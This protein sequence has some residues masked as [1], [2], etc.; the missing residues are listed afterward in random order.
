MLGKY[1]AS[2]DE[3]YQ[4][5]EEKLIA[6]TTE[7]NEEVNSLYLRINTKQDIR[8]A[9]VSL[10]AVI[11]FLGLYLGFVF[12]ISG[13]AILALKA[14]SDSIDSSGRYHMLRQ[15]GAEEKSLSL[16]LLKQQ[17][18]L[19]LL[20]LILA[21]IH[22]IFGL[23]FTAL[24]LNQLGVSH[25]IGSMLLTAVVLLVIYAGYFLVTYLSSKRVIREAP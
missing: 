4:E 9:A 1:A 21:I 14:L 2:N 25:T 5:I 24:L 17:G 15:L 20:P 18:I 19:F 12:L 8:S 13:A 6:F 16:S 23:R 3:E 11:T 22:S 10:S 7:Y